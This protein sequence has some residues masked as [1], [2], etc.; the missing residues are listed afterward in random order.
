[1]RKARRAYLA[2]F[3]AAALLAAVPAGAEMIFDGYVTGSETISVLAP[4]GGIVDD[5]MIQA[6]DR[7]A[8]GEAIATIQTTKVYAAV[9]GTVSGVFGEEGDQT[10]GI[11]ER[12][13]AVLY[14]EPVNK[15]T[16][17]A[18]TEKA[19]DVSENKFIHIGEKVFLKCTA[20]GTHQGTGIVTGIADDGKYTIEVNAGEFMLEETVNV[21]RKSDYAAAS[22]IGRG[23]V[24]AT[25]PV[26]VKGTGSILKLHVGSG[27]AVERGQLLFETVDGTLDGLYSPG[28]EIPAT[29]SGIVASVDAGAGASVEK[30][31]KIATIYP[32][33]SLQVEIPVVESDLGSIYV[34]MPVV[35]EFSWDVELQTRFDGTVTRI[36]Y[37]NTAAE[38]STE[39]S[40]TAC[41]A[42]TPD[43]HV[44]LGMTVLVY[45]QEEQDAQPDETAVP[46]GN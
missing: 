32:D 16:I 20:D 40:Y 29:A 44:R 21:F 10:D 24:A 8:L 5:V 1:M 23:T 4:F 17:T 42:F 18:S 46:E 15:Y 26:A 3:L 39:P 38:G 37:L 27:D 6:G 28:A 41:V 2:L 31:G 45:A 13:G 34:G 12:Y 33:D 7:V 22:R 19:Y 25:K 36:S 14:I 35:I 9:E 30:G 11:T 43:E